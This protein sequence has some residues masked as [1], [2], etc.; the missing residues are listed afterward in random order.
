M[1]LLREK[2][3]K[4]FVFSAV[5][6]VLILSVFLFSC[7]A[8]QDK[9][10]GQGDRNH[11][12]IHTQDGKSIPFQIELAL[13]YQQQRKGLM[14]RR[15][16]ADNAG[17]LF[18]FNM[19]SHHSFWMKNTF[20]PLDILFV[21]EDGEIH[22]IQHSATPNSLKSIESERPV[23]A[24]LELKGGICAEKGIKEGDKIKYSAFY[25]PSVQ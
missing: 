13:T 16:L 7:E 6:S 21:A 15:F 3:M 8:A 9:S 25:D 23:K 17:M 10:L 1:I 19:V 2:K 20:I 24:V 11:L 5:F 14:N 18:I 4:A 12:V 22:H